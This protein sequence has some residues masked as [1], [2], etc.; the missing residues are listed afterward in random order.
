LTTI[1][2]DRPAELVTKD[3][4]AALSSPAAKGG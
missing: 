3:L 1:D 2:G 4:L